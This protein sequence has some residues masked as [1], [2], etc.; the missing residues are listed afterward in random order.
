MAIYKFVTQSTVVPF[1]IG[2]H[3]VDSSRRQG[4]RGGEVA[5]KIDVIQTLSS[6]CL[7]C[8]TLS[9]SSR[10]LTNICD[11]YARKFIGQR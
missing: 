1:R 11:V 9:M 5:T 8:V 2:K 10:L 7:L 3:V 4:G 6:A